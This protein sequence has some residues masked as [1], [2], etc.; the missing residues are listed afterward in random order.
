MALANASGYRVGV[1]VARALLPT[2]LTGVNR[3]MG[4]RERGVRWVHH[5]HW[6]PSP[7]SPSPRLRPGGQPLALGDARG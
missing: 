4:T 7:L 6:P 5:N 1:G 2:P 3:T